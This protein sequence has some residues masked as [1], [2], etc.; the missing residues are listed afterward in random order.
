MLPQLKPIWRR[1]EETQAALLA[2]VAEFPPDRLNWKPAGN[3][4]TLAEIVAHTAGGEAAYYRMLG[5]ERPWSAPVPETPEEARS[6]LLAAGE[7][8]R[9]AFES[10]SEAD[11][12][13]PR[14]D[15]WRPLGP[16]VAGPL[17]SIWFLE[18][19]IRHK[20]Y[21][22]G[23]INYLDLMLTDGPSEAPGEH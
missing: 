15:R 17:D 10:L 11:L 8:A 20:A 1:W 2:A 3:A 21:H 5:D 7:R 13:T 12:S 14:A 16:E 9:L 22:L 23:Q 6:L 19:M 4:T 18:Q